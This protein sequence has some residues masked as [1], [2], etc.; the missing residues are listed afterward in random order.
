[1]ESPSCVESV[2]ESVEITALTPWQ[3][4]SREGR[5]FRSP[6]A[7][8]TLRLSSCATLICSDVG[9]TSALTGLPSAASKRQISLPSKPVAPT[10]RFTITPPQEKPAKSFASYAKGGGNSI[11]RFLVQLNVVELN[12]M[13]TTSV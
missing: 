5:S 7:I 1:M 6:R 12:I 8:S 11:L 13:P 4:A 9:L 2:E 3:A 10:I